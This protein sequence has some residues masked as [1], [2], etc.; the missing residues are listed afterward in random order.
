M[1]WSAE[2]AGRGKEGLLAQVESWGADRWIRVPGSRSQEVSGRF[3]QQRRF[4]TLSAG[5]S[6]V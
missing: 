3:G 6:E 2:Q 1:S 4:E 5:W